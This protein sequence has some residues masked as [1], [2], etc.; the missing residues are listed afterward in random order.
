MHTLFTHPA[1]VRGLLVMA[2]VL[3]RRVESIRRQPGVLP[4]ADHT[5]VFW[6]SGNHSRRAD[7]AVRS[8][9]NGS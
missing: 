2:G 6:S 7:E 9:R 5:L 3:F 4:G 8:Q 1:V